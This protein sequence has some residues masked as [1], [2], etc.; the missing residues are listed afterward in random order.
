MKQQNKWIPVTEQ[1]PELNQK[2]DVWVKQ[3]HIN[4]QQEISAHRLIDQVFKKFGDGR[5]AFQDESC[6]QCGLYER[7]YFIDEYLIT[8]WIPS[9]LE[10]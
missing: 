9:P 6:H 5:I 10:P 8:H 4:G 2:V 3:H 1:L 7:A